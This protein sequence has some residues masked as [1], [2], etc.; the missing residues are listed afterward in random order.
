MAT[1]SCTYGAEDL[2]NHADQIPLGLR[3]VMN[4]HVRQQ[5]PNIVGRLCRLGLQASGVALLSS[6]IV[7]GVSPVLGLTAPAFIAPALCEWATEIGV[8]AVSGWL[9]GF[10]TQA[11]RAENSMLSIESEELLLVETKRLINKIDNGDIELAI[12]ICKVI[13]KNG[14]LRVFEEEYRQSIRDRSSFSNGDDIELAINEAHN[15]IETLNRLLEDK[16]REIRSQ[17]DRI[18]DL[19]REIAATELANSTRSQ[20]ALNDYSQLN[21]SYKQLNQ[22]LSNKADCL[23]E[24]GERLETS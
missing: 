22:S 21:Q 18:S 11:A 23:T 13:E 6:I 16:E 19:E 17:E 14:L 10:A 15:L 7:A 2:P 3:Q 5:T 4:E 24:V 1:E 9:A 12:G 20:N 8:G